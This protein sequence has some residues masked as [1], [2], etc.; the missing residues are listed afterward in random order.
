M[1][2]NYS[3]QGCMAPCGVTRRQLG[4]M[5]LAGAGAA[6]A[7]A[8]ASSLSADPARQQPIRL[9][10]KVQPVLLY[11]FSKRRDKT[12]WRPWG[13]LMNEK[14]VAEE[15]QRIGSELEAAS[16]TGGF[17]M[18]ILPLATVSS[19]AEA[20]SVAATP[21]DVRITYAASGGGKMLETLTAPGPRQLIFC[22]HRSGPAYLWYEIVHPR[23][24]RK[25]VDEYGPTGM[26]VDD[27]VVDNQN[28]LV[29]RLRALYALKNTLGK[30][31]VCVGGASG[32]GAGGKKAPQLSRTI[33]KMDLPTVSYEELGARLKKARADEALLK[34]CQAQASQYLKGK[35][36]KLETDRG[37]VDRAFLLK[38]I[39]LDLM[40]EAGT[41]SITVNQCMGTIMGISETTACLPLSLL[42]DAGYMAFCESDFVV[43]PSGVLLH[44]ISGSPVFLNDPTYPHDGMVTIAHCTAPRALDGKNLEPVRILTHFESDYGASPKVEM[45]KGQKVTNLIPD[46]DMK[47]WVGFEGDVIDNPFLAI[48][49]S[50]TDIT[51]NGNQDQ[52]LR[53]MRGFHWMTSYGSFLKESAYAMKKLGVEFINASAKA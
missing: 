51:I 52:V 13:G 40:G 37:F 38:E 9:P 30:K 27:V 2:G 20:A 26:D 4:L 18:E 48:C 36:V 34:R 49:R 33:W 47:K 17:P 44:Y 25:T 7:V 6:K 29:L 1:N 16:K 53:E 42:N 28:E 41:D 21:C 45:R 3:C 32:W 22:R 39:F 23:F 10:L 43:I 24:L 5:A 11:Q 35:G 50:Q 19:D 46:F 31:I 14:D 12:S 8:G 15:K